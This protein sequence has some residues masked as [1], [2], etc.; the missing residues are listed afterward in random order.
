MA[1]NFPFNEQVVRDVGAMGNDVRV[2]ELCDTNSN[3]E[4]TLIHKADP[5]EALLIILG[6]VHENLMTRLQAP[7]NA[8]P[9]LHLLSQAE[10]NGIANRVWRLTQSSLVFTHFGLQCLS[11]TEC[12]ACHY[13]SGVFSSC[14]VLPVALPET[15]AV[16]L[17][18]T[19]CLSSLTTY[20]VQVNGDL[21]RCQC[22]NN[23]VK[24]KVTFYRFPS[25]LILQLGRYKQV[26]DGGPVTKNGKKVDFPLTGLALPN[27]LGS[28]ETYCLVAVINHIGSTPTSGHCTA[29]AKQTDSDVWFK[30]DDAT[31]TP[32]PVCDIVS[33]K[34]YVLVYEL[35]QMPL[36]PQ[37]D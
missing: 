37:T 18:L 2:M 35:R 4:P 13:K 28:T 33:D 24:K 31:C 7:D 16:T 19:D 3:P 1:S 22:G 5:A 8:L 17:S 29:Y 32:L 15:N 20:E 21:Y 11:T 9:G 27:E 14:L 6:D 30:Y 25:T 36:L 26:L 12:T 23:V 10:V 34:A